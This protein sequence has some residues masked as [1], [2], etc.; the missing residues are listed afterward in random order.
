[1]LAPSVCNPCNGWP[2]TLGWSLSCCSPERSFPERSA[3]RPVLYFPT[4]LYIFLFWKYS[5]QLIE[6]SPGILSALIFL[7]LH[8]PP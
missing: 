5:I 6:R 8:C 7:I 2:L 3:H 4:A 1:M